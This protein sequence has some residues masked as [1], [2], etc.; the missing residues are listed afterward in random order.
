[1]YPILLQL[2]DLTLPSWHAFYVLGAVLAYLLMIVVRRRLLPALDEGDLARL[3]AL[4]YVAGYFGARLL[5]IGIE[6]RSIWAAGP[7][8]VLAALVTLGPMTFYGGFLASFG[9]GLAYARLRRIPIGDVADVALPAGLLALAIGRIG[10]FLNGDD[11]GKAVPLRAD[12]VEPWW[13]VTFPNLEDGIARY[14]VQLIEAAAVALLVAVALLL[15]RRTRAAF[16]PGAVGFFAIVAYA[17]LRFALEFLR[18]DFRGFVFGTW[19]STSQFISVLIL[20]LCGMTLP[21]WIRRKQE[22][23]A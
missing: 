17:N 15:F 13:A 6:Q 10:C 11:Y 12:G 3:Y 4:C 19:L 9:A 2:G 20:L 1:M 8:A 14:P 21:L 23:A 7:G 16:R 5:S 18:D 22:G